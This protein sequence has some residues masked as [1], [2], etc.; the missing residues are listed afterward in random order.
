MK[1][2]VLQSTCTIFKKI[3][4]FNHFNLKRKAKIANESELQKM[5]LIS[6]PMQQQSK[7]RLFMIFRL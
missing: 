2:A 3:V 5:Q 4:W 6:Q 1:W 7:E